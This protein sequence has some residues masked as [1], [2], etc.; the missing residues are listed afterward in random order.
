MIMSPFYLDGKRTSY[1]RLIEFNL[2][3]RCAIEQWDV[4]G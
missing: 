4:F 2:N 3:I 1:C